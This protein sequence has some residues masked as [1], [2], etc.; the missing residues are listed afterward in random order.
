MNARHSASEGSFAR[1]AGGAA[2]RGLLLV[3]IA[4]LIGVALM[5]WGLD[6]P[7]DGSV[8]AGSN[9]T[10]TE[11]TT[12]SSTPQDTT[13]GGSTVPGQTTVPVTPLAPETIKVQVANGTA[14]AGAAGRFTEQL[15]TKNYVTLPATNA[16]AN[17]YTTTVVYFAAGNEKAPQAAQQVA[18]ELGIA[19]APSAM[20][21]AIPL[22]DPA[23]FG[24]TMVLVIIGA[25]KAAAPS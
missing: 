20:P 25:D 19:G 6:G 4:V 11:G 5:Y 23:A 1:S 22:K 13:A 17:T 3:G 21:P 12:G 2:G 24:D 9:P 14:T 7:G 15:N 16:D 10:V 18:T 8:E